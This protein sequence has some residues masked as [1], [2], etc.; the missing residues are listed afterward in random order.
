MGHTLGIH[1]DLVGRAPYADSTQ[2][3][4]AC[5]HLVQHDAVAEHVSLQ[6]AVC[7]CVGGGHDGAQGDVACKHLIQQDAVAEHISLQAA[8]GCRGAGSSGLDPCLEGAV[9]A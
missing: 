7:V 1:F 5:K 9:Q 3:D 4:V 8:G 6:A 2:G